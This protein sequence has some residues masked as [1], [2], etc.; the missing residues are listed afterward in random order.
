LTQASL[1]LTGLQPGATRALRHK[2]T[3]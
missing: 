2:E 1:I 3:V